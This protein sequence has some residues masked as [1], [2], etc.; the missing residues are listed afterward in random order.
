[1]T[2][3]SY[4][5]NVTDLHIELTDKCQASCPMCARNYNGG[6]ERPFVG[7]HDIS[8]EDFKSWFSPEFLSSIKNFYACGNYGDPII[9]KDCLEIFQYVRQHT[10]GRLSIHTN[11]S[12][13]TVKW[14]ENLA[15]AMSGHHEVT[16][17]IDGFAESHVLYRRGTDWN[18]IIEN[19]TAFI[20]AGGVATVD[21]LVFKHNEHEI[22]EFTAEMLKIGFKSVNIKSTGRFYDMEKFP[23]LSTTRETE[24]YL[25]PVERQDY[26]KINFL[27]LADLSNDI[28][29]WQD[30]VDQT[31]ILPKCIQ[32]K[33]IYVDARG[34]VY[35]CCWIGSDMIEQPLAVSLPIHDLR[36]KFVEN[37]KSTFKNFND[38]N[39]N[40]TTI[41]E[42]LNSDAWNV[43]NSNEKPWTCSKNCKND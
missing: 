18:K 29:L 27:K 31:E 2:E 14:W 17:G 16:F 23:V 34:T 13:R 20:N 15:K 9:A 26:K 12:A 40:L 1:M 7:K 24:Y 41:T 10:D 5:K 33:E 3:N 43:L 30:I 39:L 42:I 32:K 11:G 37:T 38:L 35:P 4:P 21:C 25:E 6:V 36:N 19:A 8:L 28:K 22:E